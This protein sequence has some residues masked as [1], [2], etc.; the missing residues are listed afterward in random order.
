MI[1]LQELE[2]IK[3]LKYTYLRCLDQKRWAELAQ[4]FTENAHSSYSGGKYSF[5]GR[6][7]I[8]GF[9]EESLGRDS[10]VTSH[11]VHHPE[12]DFEGPERATGTWVLE[13][14]VIDTQHELTI[15]GTGFYSD[16]YVKVGGAWKIQST[17]YKRVYEDL[18][19][20]KDRPGWRLTSNMWSSD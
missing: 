18:E 8:M 20:H 5:E 2:A 16:I 17:G 10:M 14:T 1:D 6:D 4:C 11:R 13:D 19:L 9:L 7:K 3:R 15:S 12:I